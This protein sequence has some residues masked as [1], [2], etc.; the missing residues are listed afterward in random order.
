M[1]QSVQGDTPGCRRGCHP[2][3]GT[4]CIGING[5]QKRPG[6]KF[7]KLSGPSISKHFL[8]NCHPDIPP[9]GWGH[10]VLLTRPKR[11][12][13]E[14]KQAKVAAAFKSGS[15][16]GLPRTRAQRENEYYGH[17]RKSKL[18]N[19]PICVEWNQNFEPSAAAHLREGARAFVYPYSFLL[20]SI[21]SFDFL[22]RVKVL[23][24]TDLVLALSLAGNR[25]KVDA[26]TIATTVRKVVAQV[27]AIN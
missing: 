17:A 2:S 22:N 4:G 21:S 9:H 26:I 23:V 7:P 27:S 8:T 6:G 14:K 12:L 19:A 25:H 1:P 15:T 10:G 3:S 18:W 13:S 11:F 16:S 24:R 5:I 20:R